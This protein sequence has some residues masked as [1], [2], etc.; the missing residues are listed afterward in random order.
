MPTSLRPVVLGCYKRLMRARLV[1]FNGD[2]NAI[3]K[4]RTELRMH[5][6]NNRTAPPEAVVGMVKE[7]RMKG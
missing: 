7:V 4:S 2:T 5:F 6:N 1:A 3:V